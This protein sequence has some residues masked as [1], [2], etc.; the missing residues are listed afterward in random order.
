VLVFQFPQDLSK[1]YVKRVVGVPGDTVGMSDG[2]LVV[3]RATGRGADGA[4]VP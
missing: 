2:A 4:S 1:N 3:N